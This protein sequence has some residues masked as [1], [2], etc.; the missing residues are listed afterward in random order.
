MMPSDDKKPPHSRGKSAAG[1]GMSP[2]DDPWAGW[3]P[4]WAAAEKQ[5]VKQRRAKPGA[6]KKN[7]AKQAS[8]TAGV[9]DERISRAAQS[10]HMQQEKQSPTAA[11]RLRGAGEDVAARRRIVDARLWD[12]MTTA[13]QDA[14]LQI[15]E[16]FETMGRGLGY[17]TSDWQRIPGACGA[18][19]AGAA[20]SRLIYGYIEWT[21]QC[22]REKISHAMIVDILV[23][24]VSCRQQDRDRR[25]RSGSARRN[26]M[27]GLTLYCLLQ[28]WPTVR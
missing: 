17:V 14:A 2:F 20:H 9:M 12:A 4:E 13:Q 18:G 19:N 8:K 6:S 25:L 15:A 24:G 27:D 5:T 22:H 10:V 3:K 26:L 7:G 21:K 11:V 1:R 28:G 16:A 23:F